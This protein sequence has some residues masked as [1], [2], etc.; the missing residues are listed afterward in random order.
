VIPAAV[1]VVRYRKERKNF[2]KKM[3]RDSVGEKL[4]KMFTSHW[5]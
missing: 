4:S 3:A 1:A 5:I 2:Q